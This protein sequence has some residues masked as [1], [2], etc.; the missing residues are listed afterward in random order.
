MG[1]PKEKFEVIEVEA[2]GKTDWY[3]G[4]WCLVWVYSNV[5]NFLLKGYRNECE[6]YIKNKGWKCWAVY[7]LYGGYT[8][9]TIIQTYK[10]DFD[11]SEPSRIGKRKTS[12]DYKFRIYKKG[13]WRNALLVKRLP[14]VF[15]NFNPPS[16][17]ENPRSLGTNNAL[18]GL[19][20][21]LDSQH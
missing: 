21:K 14:R 6:D 18:K 5:G 19:K 17:E 4:A 13:N 2:S 12:R 16:L 10:C 3:G 20:D 1:N 8:H 9:R 11:I 7:N 15:V